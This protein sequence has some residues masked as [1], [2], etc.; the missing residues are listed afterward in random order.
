M[1]NSIVEA[2]DYFCREHDVTITVFHVSRILNDLGLV[3]TSTDKHAGM[4]ET[5]IIIAINEDLVRN[6]DLYKSRE[7]RKY[8][9]AGDPLKASRD[10]GLKYINAVINYIEDFLKRITG[11]E[12]YYNWLK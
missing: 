3:D 6:L 9:V 11:I 2:C 5:S 4:W 1:K 7:P 8:G 12:C 10:K